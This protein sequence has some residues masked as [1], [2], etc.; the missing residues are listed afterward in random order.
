[1]T[2]QTES[3]AYQFVAHLWAH[4]Q[5]ATGRSW[6]RL[7]GALYDA[8]TLAIGAG[9][10]FYDEDFKRMYDRM[11]GSYWFRDDFGERWYTA[12]IDVGNASAIRAYEVFRGRRPFVLQ[13]SARLPVRHRLHIGSR[14]L[15]P[16]G[17]EWL[18]LTV[19]S[20]ADPTHF[21]GCSYKPQPERKRC[22]KCGHEKHDWSPAKVAKRLKITHAD[23]RAHHA[24]LEKKD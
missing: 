9:L 20:F 11:Q 18:G 19:T 2:K 6:T 5:K 1:M 21:V 22:T 3:P 8:V 16:L 10:Q 12:A 24:K 23:I 13:T 15:W 7:N 17:D 4:A 14:I